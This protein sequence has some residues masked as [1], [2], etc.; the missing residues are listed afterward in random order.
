MTLHLPYILTPLKLNFPNGKQK[1]IH[2][3][4]FLGNQKNMWGE[5]NKLKRTT[6]EMYFITEFSGNN[7]QQG[8]KYR[9]VC[10]LIF[11][12]HYLD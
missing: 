7:V 11:T 12:Q 8:H 4:L 10:L 3:I 5:Q 9:E 1:H 6:P 2:Q